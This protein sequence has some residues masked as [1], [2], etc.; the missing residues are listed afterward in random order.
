MDNQQ[1]KPKLTQEHILKMW[2][3]KKPLYRE[4]LH[5]KA[6]HYINLIMRDEGVE[7]PIACMRASNLFHVPY[8]RL[9]GSARFFIPGD[10][11]DELRGLNWGFHRRLELDYT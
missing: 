8:N 5:E 6:V 11:D 2:R 9:I 10:L 4:T 7:F 3:N 1:N